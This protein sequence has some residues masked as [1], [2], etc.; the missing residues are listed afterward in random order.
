MKAISLFV[1][2]TDTEIGKTFVSCA[3]LQGFCARALRA[4]ALK[5][6]STGAQLHNEILHNEDADLLFNA[7][8]IVLPLH[9]STPYMLRKPAAPHI[10]AAYEGVSLDIAHIVACHRAAE[11]LADIVVVEGVGGVCVPLDDM[12]D[13]ADLA[14]S[15][16]LPVIL[17]VGLRLG[18]INH[19]L[20]SAEAI[21]TRGLMLV[22]WIANIIDPDME[23]S[24]ANVEAIQQRL[25]R[26]YSAPLLGTI[27]RIDSQR[28]DEAARYID[29]DTLLERMRGLLTL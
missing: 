8:N 6:I 21:S 17:V 18:C 2:G 7:S 3:L 25:D 28:A 26:K 9:L 24:T 11:Q 20:L 29:I 5:P 10:V 13:T 15:L 4:T 22:G 23:F 1:T 19:A 12:K 14:I 16:Q 27:P